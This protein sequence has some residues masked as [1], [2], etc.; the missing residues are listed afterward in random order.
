[1]ADINKEASWVTARLME[2]SNATQD[3]TNILITNANIHNFTPSDVVRTSAQTL[4]DAEQAQVRT[5]I[6]AAAQSDITELSADITDLSNDKMDKL[7]EGSVAGNIPLIDNNLNIADSGIGKDNLILAPQLSSHIYAEDQTPYL[8]RQTGGGVEAGTRE[9]DSIVGGSVVNNQAV[10]ALSNDDWTNE[11]G[12]TVTY[13]TLNDA[14][15]SSTTRSNGIHTRYSVTPVVNHI[16]YLVAYLYSE[17]TYNQ[18]C[19]G[20]A[21]NTRVFANNWS[22]VANTWKL[23]T[24][25]RQAVSDSRSPIYFYSTNTGGYQDVKVKDPMI[26]DLTEML[27]STVAEYI[28]TN[29]RFDVLLKLGLYQYRPYTATPSLESVSGLQS[30]KTVG[31]NRFDKSKVLH[32]YVSNNTGQFI[33]NEN[34]RCTDFI[35]VFPNTKYYIRSD[36]TDG[37]WAAW[38]D[39]DK[40][41]I[42]GL[43]GY[44]IEVTSPQNAKYVRATITTATTGNVDTFCFNLSDTAR[45][46]TY[47]P[48]EEHTYPLD[49]SLT[50]RGVPAVD[51]AGNIY[52]DGDTYAPD[53]TVTRRYGIVDLGMLTW[54]Y[55]TSLLSSPC[56][57][58]NYY[59][60]R[61]LGSLKMIC[62]LYVCVGSRNDITS[63][64]QMASYNVSSDNRI[65]IRNDSYTDATAFK[66]AM[67]GV[68]LIYELATPTTETATP[69][70]AL[71]IC[72]PLGTE[73]Y[74]DERPTHVPVG[75]V[76]KYPV[77]QV[78]KLDGL[79]ADFSTLIAPTE[80][81]YTATRAYAVGR[82]LIV[83]N[84]LYKA[85]TAIASGATLTVGTNIVATTLDEVIASL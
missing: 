32:G 68:Y 54:T 57:V 83:D 36:Q 29:G 10:K 85:Q 79:P 53:G 50:L 22:T 8:Y 77:D 61:K 67:S 75:H 18:I 63:N 49:S 12:V 72:D 6:G 62:P 82:L 84:Q 40:N 13:G 44:N 66:T 45:N 17:N 47:E 39:A 35:E 33:A 4:T 71:Q 24:S 43:P 15:V 78:R 65:V 69:Y 73:E 30:H 81:T 46:G 9:Y 74:V 42:Q 23:N 76:T 20:L 11:S 21:S 51:S 7:P 19:F 31:F 14:T 80:K 1:M 52:F 28:F 64:M 5:N 26:I 58:S 56:F 55:N 27:G 2:V 60:L 48:Y 34:N 41:F 59:N 25:L 38:Y 3:G 37:A 16:Y 70:D